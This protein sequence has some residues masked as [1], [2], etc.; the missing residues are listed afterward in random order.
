MY[1]IQEQEEIEETEQTEEMQKIEEML[2]T[3]C[4]SLILFL[5]TRSKCS[6]HSPNCQEFVI[7]SQHNNMSIKFSRN[8]EIAGSPSARYRIVLGGRGI[9]KQFKENFVRAVFRKEK[10]ISM[11]CIFSPTLNSK[12][13]L[14]TY[15]SNIFD[16]MSSQDI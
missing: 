13:S 14:S 15:K 9:K 1:E 7:N 8:L 3:Q 4:C 5:E 16:Q 2:G 11:H 12:N 10:K 6:I